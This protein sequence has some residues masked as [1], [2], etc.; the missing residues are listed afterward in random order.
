M[1]METT[2]ANHHCNVNDYIETTLFLNKQQ[3]LAK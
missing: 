2:K 3:K 1:T